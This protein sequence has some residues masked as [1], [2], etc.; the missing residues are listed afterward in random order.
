MPGFSCRAVDAEF[1]ATAP[2]RWV[3]EVELDASA[4]A[5]FALFEDGAA[6]PKWFKDIRKVEWTSPRPFGVG[7]TRTVT[8]ATIKVWE[9]FFRWDP[10]RGM[11]F[12]MLST[13]LPLARAL[14]EDYRLE[15]LGPGRCRFVYTVAAEPTLLSRCLGPALR[16]N[17]ARMFGGAARSLQRYVR[18][19]RS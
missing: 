2:W 4:D 16:W 12:Y 15:P 18:D 11:S 10:G 9:H 5:V 3:N 17:F 1:F 14:A 13:S 7:T 6:W 8:L 19:A